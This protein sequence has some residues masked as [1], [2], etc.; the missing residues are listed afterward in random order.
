M[1]A[2]VDWRITLQPP[3]DS[4][5]PMLSTVSRLTHFL[6][7]TAL[8]VVPLLGWDNAS[9][10]SWKVKLFGTIDLPA[11]TP[12]GSALGPAMGDAHRALVWALLALICAHIGAALFHAFVRKDGVVQRMIGLSGSLLGLGNPGVRE[13]N[14]GSFFKITFDVQ[15]KPDAS[16]LSRPAC[17]SR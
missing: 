12:T 2:R 8:I 6:L 10:R 17:G 9:S 5:P 13:G 16:R 15:R 14:Y 7:Y 11:L 3:P 1:A 4:L